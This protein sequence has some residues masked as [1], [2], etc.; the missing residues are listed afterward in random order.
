MSGSA[1]P[2]RFPNPGSDMERFVLVYKIVY[3]ATS[4]TQFDLDAISAAL[5]TTGQASSSGAVGEEALR[6]STR[7]DRSRDPY[8][9]QSKMYSEMYRMLG[10]IRSAGGKRLL[11]ETTLLGH[12]LAADFAADPELTNGLVRESF[13]GICFPNPTTNNIGVT[14]QRPFSW[15]L[16]LMAQ[17]GGA[18]TR[19]E[20]ILGLLSVTDDLA[21][22]ALDG[23]VERIRDL[24]GGSN[25]R[26]SD[27]AEA[28]ATGAGVQFNTLKNYTRIPLSVMK[29]G[30]V[31]WGR[32]ERRTDLYRRPIEARVLTRSGRETVAW[33]SRAFDVREQSLDSFPIEARAA[34]A[35][36]SFCG[37]LLRVGLPE[38]DV[39]DQLAASDAASQPIVKR[40]GLPDDPRDVLYSPIQQ[41]P[42]GVLELAQAQ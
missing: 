42:D 2:L 39:A 6:R 11:F 4:G 26:L 28:V 24:R 30:E 36:R 14:N 34:F 40:L 3:K 20:M 25:K 9:N 21:Y 19:D 5:A 41:A 17:L 27:A 37:M 8:Y 13:L 35:T 22:G 31:G 12:Q 32:Q 38:S 18:I 33:L 29:S 7:E 15:L 10:W 23:A 1:V 16:R